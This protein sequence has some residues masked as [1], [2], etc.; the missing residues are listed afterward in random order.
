[1]A[2]PASNLAIAGGLI[3]MTSC[4]AL[5]RKRHVQDNMGRMKKWYIRKNEFHSLLFGTHD[6]M[7][8]RSDITPD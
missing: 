6:E 5:I 8:H 3:V 4:D 2:Y 7:L 1:M